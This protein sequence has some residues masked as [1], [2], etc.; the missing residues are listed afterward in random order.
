MGKIYIGN[1]EI[2]KL[3]RGNSELK[4]IYQ[5]K[6][7]GW[8]NSIG[9]VQFKLWG[10]AGGAACNCS[11]QD[12]YGSAGGFV[13]ITNSTGT[14]L[15][16]GDTLYIYV[17]QGGTQDRFTVGFGGGGAA[18]G[19]HGG[20]GGGASYVSLN[21]TATINN[22]LAVSGGG[23][24]GHNSGGGGG[25]TGQA[26]SGGIGGGGT[27]SAGGA[28]GTG[29]FGGGGSAGTAGSFLEGGTGMGCKGSGGGG[30]YYGGGGGNGDCGACSSGNSGGGS[31]YINTS[32]FDI[33]TYNAQ[34][35]RST[36]APEATSDL[37]YQDNAGQSNGTT[38]RNGLV[39]IYIAGV[40]YTFS[41][42][43]A[44]QTLIIP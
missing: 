38:G 42:T 14:G 5:G 28:A 1:T 16:S 29:G 6:R 39:V 31:S 7:K 37:D 11:L 26:G 17:G 34:S 40:K 12:T 13:D 9:V 10:A 4:E 22:L 33:T 43:G 25:S 41:Y 32:Y 3:Y 27:Q 35:D 21:G 2:Q 24:G 8:A 36:I 19:T 44:V 23:G 18:G 15:S 30:G 20:S